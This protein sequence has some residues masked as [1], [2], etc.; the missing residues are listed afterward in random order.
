MISLLKKSYDGEFALERFTWLL[1]KIEPDIEKQRIILEQLEKKVNCIET[2]SLGRVFDA[3]AAMIGLGGYNN[4]DAQLPMVLESIAA[5]NVDEQYQFTILSSPN[6]SRCIDLG[7]TI[8]QIVND[9]EKEINP[10]II[11]AKFHNTLAAALLDMAKHA[12][13]STKLNTATLS[14]G[15]FCNRYLLNRMIKLL[16]KE[17][18]K[19]LFNREVPSN[20]GGISLGQAVISSLVARRL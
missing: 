6:Q 12:R 17:D 14:G 5:E 19:V 7:I 10:G 2:S 11:S 13:E 20:D 3:V 16:K 1:N 15:V 9:I 4:F 8:K 18:F